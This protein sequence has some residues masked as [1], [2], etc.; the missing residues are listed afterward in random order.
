V[1]RTLDYYLWDDG[2]FPLDQRNE[3]VSEVIG[4]VTLTEGVDELIRGE[5]TFEGMYDSSA[6]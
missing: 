4:E 3:I 2:I 1:G 6:V 5:G